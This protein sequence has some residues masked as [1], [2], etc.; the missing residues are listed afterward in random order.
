MYHRQKWFSTDPYIIAIEPGNHLYDYI[1]K[2]GNLL[3]GSKTSFSTYDI[4]ADEILDK[5]RQPLLDLAISE[6]H[7]GHSL[8]LHH[9]PTLLFP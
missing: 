7:K 5:R 1:E 2:L 6:R 3:A 4:I 8:W 9:N